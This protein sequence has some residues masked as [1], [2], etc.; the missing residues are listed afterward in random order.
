MAHQSLTRADSIRAL[1]WYFLNLF[2]LNGVFK[3][4]LGSNNG[5]S[6]LQTST[7]SRQNTL[8][9]LPS[10]RFTLLP[11][12]LHAARRLPL[13]VIGHGSIS[14]DIVAAVDSQMSQNMALSAANPTPGGPAGPDYAKLY[15]AEAENLALAEGSYKWVGEGVE[16][17]VLARFGK[18]VAGR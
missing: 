12:E 4:I 10:P 18:R 14:A 15:K 7:T 16:D 17:R 8:A 9:A 13:L 6:L 5:T 2:G 1:S 3:L 11:F